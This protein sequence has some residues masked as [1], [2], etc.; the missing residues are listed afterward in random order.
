MNGLVVRQEVLVNL[1]QGVVEH[2]LRILV[3]AIIQAHGERIDIA[4][5]HTA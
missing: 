4:T 5:A 2:N 1:V 3:E